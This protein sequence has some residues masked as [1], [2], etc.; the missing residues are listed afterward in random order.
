MV[1]Y[2]TSRLATV[3]FDNKRKV[4]KGR[5]GVANQMRPEA[6]LYYAAFNLADLRE[7]IW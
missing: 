6:V 3:T 4:F 2:W 5:I 1:I 7:L